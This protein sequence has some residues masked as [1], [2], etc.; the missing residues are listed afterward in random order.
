MSE[1]T[2]IIKSGKN[3]YN[4]FLDGN[5]FCTLNS[6][7]ILKSGLKIGR[8]ISQEEIEIIQM[9]NERLVAFDKSLKYIANIKTEKQVKDYLYSKGYTDK[10]VNYCIT[11]LKEYKYLNDEEF[12]KLYVKSYSCKKGKRLLEFELKAK[13]I[14]K[15]IIKQILNKLPDN[16]EILENLAQ[17]FLK[18]KPKDKKTAQ[19]LF[20]HLF[21]KGFE[22]EEINKTIRK[23]IFNFENEE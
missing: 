1:I 22:F 23:H 8:E 6:E 3:K 9:E 11:K 14:K 20:A 17:K 19:K 10:T 21:S 2:N 7:T 13:G 12:A 18:N 16:E 15:E 5:F 4:I